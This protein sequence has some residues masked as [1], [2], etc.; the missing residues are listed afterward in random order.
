MSQF[1]SLEGF[2]NSLTQVDSERTDVVTDH[3]GKA[4]DEVNHS[5]AEDASNSKSKRE[6]GYT[7]SLLPKRPKLDSPSVPPIGFVDLQKLEYATKTLQK[8]VR[9]IVT[10]SPDIDSIEKLL[11]SST[12]DSGAKVDLKNNNYIK[13]ASRLKSKYKIG[14]LPIFD[15]ITAGDIKISDEE[16]DKIAQLNDCS[17]SE[18]SPTYLPVDSSST[19][20]KRVFTTGIDNKHPPLPFIK[21]QTLYERVF[22]HKSVV[23]GKT[24]LDQNDL[25]NSHNERLEFLG[26]SVLNNL[27]TLIIYDKFPSASEGKLTKM[28]SQLIDNHTLTQFSFEYGFDKRLKTKTDE[29]ILKTGDQKVYAD[30]FEAYIGALS[31]ERGLDLREIKD[32]LEKLYAPKLEAFK[33]NFLQESV[34][35][36]AKSELYSIVGT[37]SS[38]PLYVVVE[39]G[40]GSHDFVVECR[41]GNDVLG[42]AK[43]P[44]QKEAGL[45]AAMDALKNRQL[46]EKYY[47]IRLEIDR[48]D[49]V[50]SSKSKRSREEDE[51]SDYSMRTPTPSSP[52]KTIMF[53]LVASADAPIDNNA[54]NKLYAEIGK[55]LGEVP[56]YIVSRANNDIA[57]VS[58]S[59]RGLVVA[60]AT[61]KS[62]KKAMARAA[63]AILE[64]SSAL[65]EIC[66][67]TI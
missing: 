51:D 13:V 58:L 45:R 22:V 15:E 48:K 46:L 64:N 24:Y 41:M 37:A 67:G 60:T 9:L 43:A 28:R 50:K 38:H 25:I 26:D 66:K 34:N 52:I 47:K 62:K 23:N 31:V 65:N 57:A 63:M 35:K 55:R 54:K 33:V 3:G 59:I 7:G 16:F 32:W 8:N 19:Q 11:N 61:D 6:Y 4:S 40:N 27:V 17:D 10:E 44:S 21:D 5:P 18:E 20:E 2:L 53:P 39:E 56:Q 29:E 36:E 49:S 1:G 30:I 12:L 42:R 14:K